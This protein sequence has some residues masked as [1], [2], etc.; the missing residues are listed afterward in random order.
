M[1]LTANVVANA[2]I[3][4]TWGN[5]IRDRSVQNFASVAERTAQ[6]VSPPEGAV[7]YVR[8]VNQVHVYTGSA[9]VCITPVS[10]VDNT[11]GTRTNVAYGDL[12][13]SSVGPVVSLL[14]GTRALVYVQADFNASGGSEI[15]CVSFAI[16][17][18]TTVAA[19]D[20]DAL[21][22]RAAAGTIMSFGGTFP[23]TGLTPGTNTFTMKYRADSGLTIT[24]ASR[25]L[26][27]VGVP[28]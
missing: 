26:T 19:A 21:R 2:P 15:V 23:V 6:W 20:T 25:K 27:V 12:G 7:S 16:S 22:M 5:E 3:T 9:W 10:T 14:T 17:G 4:A 28:S 18:A 24:A 13:G 1:G 11:T 8:D